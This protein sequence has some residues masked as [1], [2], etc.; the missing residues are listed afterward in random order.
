M[1]ILFYAF[2][3]SGDLLISATAEQINTLVMTEV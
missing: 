3:S 2:L 1:S